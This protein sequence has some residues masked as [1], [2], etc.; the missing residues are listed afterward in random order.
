M[1]PKSMKL[2][3]RSSLLAIFVICG[4]A[5]HAQGAP[6]SG[7]IYNLICQT[8]GMALDNSGGTTNGSPVIQE[9]L[10]SGDTNQEWECVSVS[11]G[12][13]NL[14]CQT[15]G[16]AL[17]NDNG[18]SNGNTVW[19]WTL[20][21]GNTNQEWMPVSV[22][23]GYYNLL[24]LT[25]G[26]ALD[27]NNSTTAGTAVWQWTQQ[28]DNTNQNW[29]FMLASSSNNPQTTLYV[30]PWGSGSAFS[31]TQPGSLSG[32]Q[33]KVRT[34][35][36]TMTGNIIVYLYGGTYQLT[37]SFT[38][39]ENSTTHDSGTGGHNVI[40]EAYPGQVPVISGGKTITGWSVYNSSLNIYRASV[41]TGVN[42]RQ[43]YVNGVR[44]IRA[45]SDI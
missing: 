5:A 2:S 15:G 30:A 7:S 12:Y 10:Q 8:S 40:Y 19:Q 4:G 34:L 44:A 27:N 38:L 14:I 24:C 39:V 29:E 17:D 42:S 28:S 31:A 22:G 6:K 35:T 13:Y 16:L 25:G 20:Q 43:L 18:T 21:S 11:G 41:G 45:R 3:F 9:P 26:V 32:A 33:A 36:P 1:N 37:S 23:G